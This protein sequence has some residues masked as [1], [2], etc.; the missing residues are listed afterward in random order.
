MVL[1]ASVSKR[2]GVG[3]RGWRRKWQPT[4]AFLPGESQGWGSL[5]GSLVGCRLWGHTELDTTEATQQQQQQQGVEVEPGHHLPGD[6]CSPSHTSQQRLPAPSLQPSSLSY[7]WDWR[8]GDGLLPFSPLS[9]PLCMVPELQLPKQGLAAVGEKT[10][11]PGCPTSLLC[12]SLVALQLLQ[13]SQP[14]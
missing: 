9:L 3:R 11:D 1:G 12:T 6:V 10:P 4:P 2:E 13:E 7:H 5:G 14:R 8:L